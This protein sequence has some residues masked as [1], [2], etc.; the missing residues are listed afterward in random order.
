L[1][2]RVARLSLDSEKACRDRH[3]TVDKR[4]GDLEKTTVG[5]VSESTG[6]QSFKA[7]IL[8]WGAVVVSMIAASAHWVHALIVA[9]RG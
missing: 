9:L 8:M 6:G 4:M 7:S 1:D 2:D 3:E 5:V